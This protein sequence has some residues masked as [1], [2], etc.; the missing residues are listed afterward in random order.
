MRVNPLRHG[1]FLSISIL[2]WLCF[3]T[4]LLAHPFH[5]CVGQMKWNA[6]TSV[7]EVS[8]RLH[9]QDLEAA[10]SRELYGDQAGRKVSTEETGF[11]LLAIKYLDRH[12]FFRRTPAAMNLDEIRAI[13]RSEAA[14]GSAESQSKLQSA[15]PASERSSLKWVGSEQERGWLWIH[16]EMKQPSIEKDMHRLWFVHRLLLDHV[17]RQENTISMDPVNTPKL[18]FQFKKDEEIRELP[19]FKRK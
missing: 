19:Y 1:R 8:L 6:K 9:P 14:V 7:W 16:L 13:L 3:T 11:A 4:Q 2:V 5:L 17:D 15:E 18:S 10:M 12:F